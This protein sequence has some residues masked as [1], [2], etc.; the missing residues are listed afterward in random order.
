LSGDIGVIEKGE[1]GL[2]AGDLIDTLP[3][4]IQWVQAEAAVE[5][6]GE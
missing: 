1:Y 6:R 3:E 4:A 5:P 2:I